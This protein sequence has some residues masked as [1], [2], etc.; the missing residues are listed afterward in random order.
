MNVFRFGILAGGVIV[1]DRLTKILFVH[2][3][4]WRAGIVH[5][6]LFE[7]FGLVFSVPAPSWVSVTVMAAA[8]VIVGVMFVRAQKRQDHLVTMAM[9]LIFLGALSNL[10]DRVWY[11]YVID[12]VSFGRWF[13]IFNLADITIAAGLII[14]IRGLTKPRSAS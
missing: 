12:F 8:M 5:L 9:F 7:N 6:G 14:W 2:G 13:P 10:I 11:G 3:A 1:L 4:D